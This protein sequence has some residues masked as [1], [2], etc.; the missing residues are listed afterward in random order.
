MFSV[1]LA[2]RTWLVD[3]LKKNKWTYEKL[4]NEIGISHGAIG[5]WVR[6]KYLPDPISL[7]KL[8]E[9]AGVGDVWL[10]RIVGYLAPDDGAS[11]PS[12]E[13][14]EWV[15][16]FSRILDEDRKELLTLARMKA[17]RVTGKQETI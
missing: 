17:S 14:A 11:F 10:F 2:F 6:G 5:G 16:L 1:S 4:G 9:V 13:M 8:A 7:R 15:G 12:P 3:Q